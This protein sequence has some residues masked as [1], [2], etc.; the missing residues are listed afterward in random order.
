VTKIDINH[1]RL[2]Y[3][4]HGSGQALLFI[5]GLGSSTQDWEHQLDYFLNDF[6]IILVDLRGHGQSDKP[7]GEYNVPMFAND[8]AELLMQ[9]GE[10]QVH[11]VGLSLGAWVAYQLAVDYP[12]LVKSLVVVNCL[13]E[14]VAHSISDRLALLKRTILF[15][16]LDMRTIGK[17]LSKRLF[18][19]ETQ[20]D[21][22]QIFIERWAKNDKRAYMATLR[23]AIGW[24]IVHK[25]GEI[26]CPCSVISAEHDYFPI[27]QK[28]KYVSLMP[29]A[30]LLVIENC[31]HAVP[32]ECPEVFNKVLSD[33]LKA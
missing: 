11:V 10:T 16:I 20:K 4:S 2:Y 31:G 24:S 8:V 9:V 1:T 18:P 25:L 23:G 5:H 26:H 12:K 14:L 28:Q 15:R 19:K 21:L 3:E 6:R 17:L 30:K 13:P 7:V 22:R 33:T 27:E 32:F 29:N